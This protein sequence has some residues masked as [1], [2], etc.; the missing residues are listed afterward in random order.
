MGCNL[1]KITSA[2]LFSL[3]FISYV[4]NETSKINRIRHAS[5][6]PLNSCLRVLL[7]IDNICGYKILTGFCFKGVNKFKK[8]LKKRGQ[9]R[10]HDPVKCLG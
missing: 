7:K 4:C 5:K 8:F 6:T 9:K 10:I 1:S 2:N 3:S